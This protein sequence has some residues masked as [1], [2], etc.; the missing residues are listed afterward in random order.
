M[1]LLCREWMSY[2][3][4]IPVCFI[5]A[6]SLL[7]H[8]NDEKKNNH[9][10]GHILSPNYSH[11]MQQH[12][13]LHGTC[14]STSW[15]PAACL[16][17][18]IKLLS[19]P[20]RKNSWDHRLWQEIQSNVRLLVVKSESVIHFFSSFTGCDSL[21]SWAVAYILHFSIQSISIF[22]NMCIWIC[23]HSLSA[24]ALYYYVRYIYY[25]VIITDARVQSS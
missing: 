3:S 15:K 22:S 6:V 19:P 9:A 11:Q 7:G 18:P 16:I 24:T 2:H 20:H 21:G 10:S 12:F 14:Y 17:T 25:C 23:L 13:R 8:F 4:R 5:T 1:Y